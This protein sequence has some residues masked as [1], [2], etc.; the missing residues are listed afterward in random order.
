MISVIILTYNGENYIR[1]CMDSVINQT[2]GME[3]IEIIIVDDASTDSTVAIL[4]EYEERYPE[5][6]CLILREINSL[7]TGEVNRNI[8]VEYASG[9]YILFLDQDDWYEIN[10]F[11]TLG[12]IAND[13]PDIDYIEYG[14][15]YTDNDGNVY[16]VSKPLRSG[17]HIYDIKDEDA[18][19]EYAKSGVL[20]GATFVW[21]KMYRKEFLVANDIYHNDGEMRTGFSDNFFSGLIVMY[22]SKIAKL[23]ISLYNYRNYIGSYSHDARKNSKVQLERCKAGIVFY[24]ECIRRGLGEANGEVVEY[25]FTRTFLLKTFWKFLLQFD[26]IPY[27]ILA[28]IQQEMKVRCPKYM[29]NSIMKDKTE[30]QMVLAVLEKEWTP[31]FLEGLSSQIRETEE[32]GNLKKYMYLV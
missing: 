21:N 16:K 32:N 31:E 22:A 25:I 13:N 30:M 1:K 27:E 7:K 3:Q 15:C 17:L 11:E 8:G 5:N 6:I 4:K 26:P 12:Q 9:E 20:P 29:E 19:T 18:R 28:F 23:D 2:I 14:F 24:D 10:A